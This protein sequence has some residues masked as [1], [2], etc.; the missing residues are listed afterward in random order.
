CTYAIFERGVDLDGARCERRRN[1]EQHSCKQRES[2][3]AQHHGCVKL[4]LEYA[5]IPGFRKQAWN[6]VPD[7]IAEQQTRASRNRGQ[8]QPFREKLANH[9]ASCSAEREPDADLTMTSR[10]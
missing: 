6:G 3:H 1:A 10:G 7:R 9:T 5:G 2:E 4:G 8:Q